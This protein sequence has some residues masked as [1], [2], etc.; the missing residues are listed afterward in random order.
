DPYK[1]AIENMLIA[2]EGYF[3]AAG[4]RLEMNRDAERRQALHDAMLAQYRRL[5]DFLDWQS[6]G[7]T[8]LFERFGLAEAVFTPMFVRFHFLDYYENFEL[9]AEGF[10][11][12]ARWREACLAH[13]A[14]QQ[15]ERE[16]VI[17]LYYDY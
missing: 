4:Y 5:Q 16:R 7:G 8:F 9:P 15:V 12:V 11:R 3:T 2:V 14:A 10:E 1:R 13:P 17:K 6:P